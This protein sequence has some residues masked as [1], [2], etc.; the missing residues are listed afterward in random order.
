M[1]IV[2][3]TRSFAEPAAKASLLNFLR[4]N[5]RLTREHAVTTEL[6]LDK[7]SVRADVVL[8]SSDGLHCFEI[9]TQRDT[10][11]RLDNQVATYATHSDSVTVVA[12]TKHINA[13]L[14]RVPDY[15]GVFELLSFS[16]IRVVRE[17]SA[18]PVQDPDAM[19][20][21]LPVGEI[22][23]RL[24]IKGRLRADV[25]KAA[26]LLEPEQKKTA[27]LSFFRERYS[28]TTMALLKAVRRRSILPKDL[29]HLQRWL[30]VQQP[31]A[32][33]DE[34]PPV[35]SSG[36]ADVHMY[37]QVGRSFSPVPDDVR[38]LLLS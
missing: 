34:Q 31:A 2:A 10:L 5:N 3:E 9:K 11:A 26:Q 7:H 21:I 8:C 15:V 23:I 6:I 25:L 35:V 4:E 14:S 24:G 1:R 20:S 16:G 28:S 33:L 17:A 30:K 38:R 18:S 32:E 19:L 27:V 29:V 36:C 22:V 12:A 37:R 13:V